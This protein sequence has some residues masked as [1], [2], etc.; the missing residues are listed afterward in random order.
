MS[1]NSMI[2]TLVAI[3][4][5][6]QCASAAEPEEYRGVAPTEG[7]ETILVQGLTVKSSEERTAAWRS[8]Y[9]GY[10]EN[11]AVA[12]AISEEG[13]WAFG[14]TRR[15]A[16]PLQATAG[17]MR[18]CER[19]RNYKSLSAPCELL[20]LNEIEIPLG[21]ALL[22]NA[23]VQDSSQPAPVWR[24][25]TGET[26]IY[27]AANLPYVKPSMHPLLPVLEQAF[28]DAETVIVPHRPNGA[29]QSLLGFA[30][31]PQALLED[32][33]TLAEVLDDDLPTRTR[34][35][36]TRMGLRWDMIARAQPIGVAETLAR[37]YRV[38]QSLLSVRTDSS[39]PTHT[40]SAPARTCS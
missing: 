11:K 1:R 17:A 28:E 10:E 31:P 33:I 12:M 32:D 16:G 20:R 2:A 5:I 23:D 38:T 19:D 39:T 26:Q 13:D 9:A 14:W 4:T 18:G 27:L 3:G 29:L 30:H 25:A 37:S 35:A 15:G 36:L 6:C 22:L 7:D 8:D 21:R 24:F 40:S 34:K